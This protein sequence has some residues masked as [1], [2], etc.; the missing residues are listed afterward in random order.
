MLRLCNV[1]FL[2]D[3][4]PLP[5]CGGR[6]GCTG[7]VL[8]KRVVSIRC[9]RVEK[10]AVSGEDGS[11]TFEF[12]STPSVWR[13]TTSIITSSATNPFQSTPSVWRE[14]WKFVRDMMKT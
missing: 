1:E 6:R 12:Q 7:A 10:D 5:P 14:T 11:F 4:N 9:L 3:F 2:L 13:E 8:G